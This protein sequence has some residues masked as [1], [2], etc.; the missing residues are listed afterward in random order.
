MIRTKRPQF[1]KMISDINITPFT[2]VC[3]VLLIIF[4]VTASALTRE[5]SL[6]VNLPRAATAE[7]PMASSLT[8]RITRDQELFLN[9]EKVTFG[10]LGPLIAR[11]HEKYGTRLLVVRADEGI[12]YR[13][14]IWAIDIA[15]QAGVDQIALATREPE[16]RSY[17]LRP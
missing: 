16:S 15:R 17:P 9:Y 8:V 3:L 1:V 5:S 7:V 6:R 13:L 11:H 2:D 4:M 14:V 10:T 12:P